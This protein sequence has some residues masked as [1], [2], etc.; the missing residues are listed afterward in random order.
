MR[1]CNF[2][3][4]TEKHYFIERNGNDGYRVLAARA[5][6][7]SAIAKTEKE[8]IALA[9]RF[10]PGDHPDVSRVRSTKAGGPDRGVE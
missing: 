4:A 8:A 2:T 7:A 10:N 3:L 1:R 5:K 9:R 6:R